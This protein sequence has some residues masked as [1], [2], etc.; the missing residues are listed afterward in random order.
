MLL[1]WLGSRAFRARGL[2]YLFAVVGLGMEA[3]RVKTSVWL[4]SRQPDRGI[5]FSQGNPRVCVGVEYHLMLS[6]G[7]KY[8]YMP[9]KGI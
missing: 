7:R 3:R 2:C 4:D 8:N 1:L 9:S 5:C 6:L